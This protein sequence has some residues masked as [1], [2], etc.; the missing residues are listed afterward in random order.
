[1]KVRCSGLDLSDAINKVI[2]ATSTKTINGILEGIKLTAENNYLVLTAT[3]LE[4]G[5]EKKIKAE[6]IIEGEAVVPGKLFSEY[7]RKL[8]NEEVELMLS[9]NNQLK[10]KYVD[11]EG[12]LQCYNVLEFPNLKKIDN[13]EYFSLKSADLKTLINKS[14]LAVA[15]DDSRPI[16]K[17]VLFEVEDKEISA[18]ALDG[19]RLALIT[20]SLIHSTAR[21][22]VVIP[23]RSLGEIS[24]LLD[25]TDEVINIYIQK[26]Y[27]MVDLKETIILTRLLDG[28]FINYKKIIPSSQT[29]TIVLNR[30]QFENALERASLLSK[31]DRN[32][33]IKFDIKEKQLTIT[34]NNEF[35]S[36]TENITI[37]LNGKDLKIAFNAKYILEVLR[38]QSDEFIR[39]NFE[40]SIDPCIIKPE[41]ENEYLYLILPVRMPN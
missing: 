4:L 15:L 27:L 20:K 37:A 6:V 21:L 11:S 40:T 31:V 17:G 18:V 7:A 30:E 12:I 3:D 8:I 5:I 22:S 24:K 19:Y 32:N 9:E 14:I 23:S 28:D 26:N 25:D 41:N 34:S 29:T 33:I 10:I 36:I 16:L 1:M 35:G 38:N 13:A 39:L 2:K